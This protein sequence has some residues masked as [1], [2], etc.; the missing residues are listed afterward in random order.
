M[1]INATPSPTP[2]P[3]PTLPTHPHADTHLH[4][5][6]RQDLV[7]QLRPVGVNLLAQPLH[8]AARLPRVGGEEGEVEA[9]GLGQR[10]G[11][12][13]QHRGAPD[14]LVHGAEAQGGQPRPHLLRHKVEIVDQVLGSACVGVVGGLVV[15]GV[16]VRRRRRRVGGCILVWLW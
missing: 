7:V 8:A 10:V 16:A 5:C 12:L 2:P 4:L 3:T 14:E 1:A 6:V 15:V 13:A 9:G 11:A